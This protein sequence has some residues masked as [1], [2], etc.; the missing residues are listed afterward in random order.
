MP[1]RTGILGCFD[2]F[3]GLLDNMFCY[4]CQT[5]R[6]C[7]ALDGHV[8]QGSCTWCCVGGF[9]PHVS[10]CVIRRKVDEKFM[11]GESFGMSLILGLLCAPCSHCQTHRELTLQGT[12]PG[13]VCCQSQPYTSSM[14]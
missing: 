7:E 6:Q 3:T 1:Y 13:G 12:W 10:A 4:N 14:S 9:S 5:G 2:D 8:N 11:I